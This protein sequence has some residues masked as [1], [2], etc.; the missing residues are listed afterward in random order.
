MSLDP[1]DRK[2]LAELEDGQDLFSEIVRIARET[3]GCVQCQGGYDIGT[4]TIAAPAM[5]RPTS[6]LAPTLLQI[7]TK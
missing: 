2:A 5:Q 6:C 1:E 7:F 4:R 3:C